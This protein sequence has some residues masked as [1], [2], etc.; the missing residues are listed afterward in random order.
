L[1]ISI[2]TIFLL[3]LA[4]VPP[5]P[6][7]QDDASYKAER[8]RA[9]ELF[10]KDLHLQALPVFAELAKKNPRD[11]EVL[12][13]LATCMISHANTVEDDQAAAA[14]RVRARELL[15][16]AKE[17]G[18]TSMLMENLLQTIPVDGVLIYASTPQD[19]AMRAGEAAF[20]RRDFPEAIRQYSKVLE[21]DPK[22]Y[23]AALFIGDTYF[24]E[25]DFAQAAVWYERAIQ[26][27][28]NRETAYRY[29][30]DMLTRQ[31]DMAKARTMAI[32]AVIA[33]PYNPITWRGLQAWARVNQLQLARMHMDIPNS[34]TQSGEKN[35]T[36]NV[37]PA[38]SKEAMGVWLSY[39]LARAAWSGEKFKK[40]FPQEKE[41]RHSLAE[42][43]DALT[44]AA[45]VWKELNEADKKPASTLPGDP[46]LLTL[47]K[48]HR[49]GMLEP[50]V[51]LNAADAGIAQDYEAY[52]EKN[53]A[54]LEEYL[55]T[56][57]V[58]PAPVK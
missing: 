30:S 6:S 19:Q 23:S 39:G 1:L 17:L 3:G 41:Y 11:H 27:G 58:P 26:L 8:R 2:S 35:L 53:R 4:F 40:V 57:V 31:G 43:V 44:S 46:L 50:Y 12:V 38:Q 5:A 22:N 9:F 20:G 18:S 32:R 16:K 29:Y 47:V 10:N 42:E 7:P 28:P 52:R 54:K 37:D 25:K 48:L 51:L 45:T 21:L 13:G 56:F 36:I 24:T 14:E 33:E 34:V 55:S 49:S 15:L